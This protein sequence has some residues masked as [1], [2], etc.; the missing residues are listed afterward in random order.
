MI[1][2]ILEQLLPQITQIRQ[3]I[4]ANPELKY[5]EHQT[6]KLVAQTLE[7]WGYEV[8]TGIAKTGVSAIIDSG[9]P[10]KTVALRGDMD[11]LPIT[12]KTNLSYASKNIGKMHACGH[13]GHTATLLAIAGALI[14]CRD[15]FKG[16]IKLIFQ[17]AEE[18]GAGAAV[19]IQEGILE[20][21]DAIFGY[22]NM[23]LPL[24]KVAVKSACIFAG[25]DF[26]KIHIYGK[27]SH[28]A[29]PHKSVDPIWVGSNIVQGLQA[30][31]SRN[32]AAIDPIVLSVTEFHAG[33]AVNIIPETASLTIS[34]RTTSPAIRNVAMQQCQ[35]IAEGIAA[36]F[37]AR[38]E[39]E[40]IS[41]CP[42]TMNSV[43]ESDLVFQTAAEIYSK[44]NVLKLINPFMVTEDFAFFLEKIPGCFFL[45]GNGEVNADLHT[46][47]YNFQDSIIPIAARVMIQSA[48]NFL[49]K[50]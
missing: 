45:V 17:P 41:T 24:G 44:E 22:H 1:Q 36:S 11:A 28:A 30:I 48:F 34:L 20:N 2:K 8:K 16:K 29:F 6:A 37:G 39:I 14:Q 40:M 35:N 15:Q 10:G 43:P 4:Y 5:E 46:P 50:D 31:V 26:F 49:N 27:G 23:P 38:A 32:T 12:E 7:K 9:K 47:H 33:N 25:A 3:T 21:V 42:P 19:M 18:G 13:D